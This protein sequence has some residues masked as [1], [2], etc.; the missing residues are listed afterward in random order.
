MLVEVITLTT[1]VSRMFSPPEGWPE[2]FC[3]S[4]MASRF[5]HGEPTGVRLC[6]DCDEI[7][8]DS[9]HQAVNGISADHRTWL[10]TLLDDT[11]TDD[12]AVWDVT[13][14]LHCRRI[15]NDVAQFEFRP[16]ADYWLS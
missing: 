16:I 13:S 3:S 11:R 1:A 5:R 2:F 10:N 6:C 12:S 14:I 4:D 7:S 15:I 8:H 9:P